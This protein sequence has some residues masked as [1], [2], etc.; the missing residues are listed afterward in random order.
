MEDPTAKGAAEQASQIVD[1]GNAVF[2]IFG[3]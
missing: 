3:E 2:A 1:L